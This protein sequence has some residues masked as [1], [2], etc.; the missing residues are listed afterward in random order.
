M[1][2]KELIKKLKKENPE[3]DVVIQLIEENDD[4]PYNTAYTITK[5]VNEINSEKNI[6]IL[7]KI[8]S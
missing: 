1:K 8:L 4:Y 7:C 5:E 6:V 2:V 3:A